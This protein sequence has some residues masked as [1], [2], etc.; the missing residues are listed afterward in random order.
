MKQ[1]R[2]RQPGFSLVELMIVVA[3]VAVLAAIAIPTYMRYV[4]HGRRAEA[5]ALL[6]Q[7][8]AM[9]ERCYAQNFSY[10]PAPPAV[11][12]APTA[13]SANGY[14]VLAPATAI[15]ASGYTLTAVPAGPQ[16]KDTDCASFTVTSASVRSAKNA[17]NA[18]NTSACWAQ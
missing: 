8:Q 14:Y 10:A 18:D 17:A 3:I 13:T 16:A 11:C 5:Y 9:L 1:H 7:D 2:N 15:T 12:P 6:N 4:L